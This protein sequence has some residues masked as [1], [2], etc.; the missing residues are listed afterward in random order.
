MKFDELALLRAWNE[1]NAKSLVDYSE[2]IL[3]LPPAERNKD[4][5]ASWGSI[6][7][8]FLH[9]VEDYVWWYENVPQ[10]RGED[11]LHPQFVGRGFS[12]DELRALVRRAT[13]TARSFIESLTPE[14]LG[15]PYHVRGTSGSG[16]PYTMT[17]CP[18][19]IV[20]HMVE[21][22]LQHIG[23]LNALFWQIGV[24]PPTHAWFSSESA[25]TH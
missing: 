2:A 10:G 25:W 5:G 6:Q 23:E 1:W 17:T 19:D 9:V 12:D 16:R 21:E 7:D 14:D 11:Q 22:Q 13:R 15:R 20:W 8:V 4:R 24:N 3:R 18:A